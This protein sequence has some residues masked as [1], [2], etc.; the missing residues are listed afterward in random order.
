MG[1]SEEILKKERLQTVLPVPAGVL[2]LFSLDSE[3]RA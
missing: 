1:D 2:Q 3:T